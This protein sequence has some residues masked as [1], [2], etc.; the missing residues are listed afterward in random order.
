MKGLINKTGLTK[1]ELT[2]ISFLLFTFAAGLIVKISGWQKPGDLDYS[3][4]DS[5]FEG[6]LKKSFRE[7]EQNKVD[8][9]KQQRLTELNLFTDSLNHSYEITDKKNSTKLPGGK[10]NINLALTGDLQ[11]LPGIGTVMAERI[12]EYREKNGS[13]SKPEDLMKVKGIGE[14]KF[15]KIRD[16]LIVE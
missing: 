11:L 6:Q 16:Y 2:V 15:E 12:I 4:S 7:L 8:S 3:E 14:K 1:K 13:F 9:L 10:I 5:R